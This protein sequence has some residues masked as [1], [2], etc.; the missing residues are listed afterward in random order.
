MKEENIIPKH[1]ALTL[2]RRDAWLAGWVF[3]L[4]LMLFIRTL[5]PGLLPGDSGELQTLAYL[6]GDTH[7][8]GY[9][10]YLALA[11]VVTFLPLHDIAWRVNLFSALMAALTVGGFY[12]AARLLAQ[13]RALALAGA[14]LLMVAPT[15]WSQAVI[16]EVYAPGAAFLVV[17]LSLLL[18]WDQHDAG[19]ALFV[20]GGLGG[21]SLGVH[22]SV[23]LIA[24]AV[25]FF[26]AL[27]WRR[28]WR[29]WG[30]AL[31]G[32]A[33]GLALTLVLFWLIDYHDPT[34]NYFRAVILPSISAWEMT[35]ADL[36]SPWQRLWFS[37]SAHQFRP[38]M[39]QTEVLGEQ[40]EQFWQGLPTEIG[41]I[42]PWLAL[43]GG[44]WLLW[45]RTRAGLLLILA[46]GLQLLFVFTY[47]IWDLYVF[48]IPA[49]ILILLL[50]VAG[51][52]ASADGLLH[53]V[54]KITPEDTET[55]SGT[56]IQGGLALLL[57][58]LVAWPI[59][60][61][62]KD[63]VIAGSNSFDFGEYPTYS[64]QL[65][66]LAQATVD[67]LPP[68]AI[69]F[70]D[71]DELWPL[72]YT[73][74]IMENRT[75]LI[76]HETYPRDDRPELADSVITYIHQQIGRRP[77]FFSEREPKLQQAGFRLRIVRIGP[78]RLFRVEKQQ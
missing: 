42:T 16:A 44:L 20:A 8:T 55:W 27:H 62:Q 25:L 34:A 72:T 49:H 36:A 37:W 41:V 12:L 71:W 7:P 39:Y 5:T 29:M 26:L 14:L 33:A 56:A 77:V 28:G 38:F 22:M 40:A 50:A 4:A 47:A 43:T 6:L 76:F 13:F 23:A 11:K 58:V 30:M 19:W 53:L 54:A 52:S 31:A 3:F 21:L 24:P 60:Q 64:P 18:W 69:L 68:D 48:F 17:I 67:A 74:H 59:F 46:L 65:L 32:A 61:P 70:T 57:L 66:H 75:D 15:F 35:P 10:I 51:L 73:A 78:Q 9:P 45:R 1:V 63:A 2:T